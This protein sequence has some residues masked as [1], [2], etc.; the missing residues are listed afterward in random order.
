MMIPQISNTALRQVRTQLKCQN[1]PTYI[2]SFSAFSRLLSSLAVLEQKD[3][4]L[5]QGALGSVTA[6]Q[7]LGSSI[8]GFIAGNNIKAVAEEAAKV[9]GIEKIIA[10]DNA[11]YD[12]VGCVYH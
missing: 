11:A 1:G 6:A 3:G 7:K 4:K 12:K 2:T 5:L 10:V 9:K 8:T